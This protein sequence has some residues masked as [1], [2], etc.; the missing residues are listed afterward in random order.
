[1]AESDCKSSIMNAYLASQG[2]EAGGQVSNTPSEATSGSCADVAARTA[3]LIAKIM[4]VKGSV[5]KST[6]TDQSTAEI[7]GKLNART[8]SMSKANS[9]GPDMEK[10]GMA[11]ELEISCMLREMRVWC[12]SRDG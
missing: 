4:A 12:G 9:L 7:I 1:M 3:G 6:S 2:T 5:S 11:V 8:G 10:V